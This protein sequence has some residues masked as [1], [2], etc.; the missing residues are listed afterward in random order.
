MNNESKEKGFYLEHAARTCN[1]LG[2]LMFTSIASD[3]DEHYQRILK[4]HKKL[5][6][7]GKWPETVPIEVKGT[8]VK[9]VLNKIVDTVATSSKSDMD[10]V[11]AVKVAIDFETKGEMFYDK[12]AKEVDN[13]ME[14]KFYEF[15]A[16]IEREHR[17]SLEDAYEYFRDPSSWFRVKEKLNVDGQ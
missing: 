1:A 10:D 2:K 5:T 16:G 8:E 14:K 11:E 7:D 17:L 6:S 15:L 13:P 3:E 12:L 4:L 9:A